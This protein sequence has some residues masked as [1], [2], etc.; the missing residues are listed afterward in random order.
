MNHTRRP[1]LAEANR[2]LTE[3]QNVPLPWPYFIVFFLCL[4]AMVL[5]PF[6]VHAKRIYARLLW[7]FIGLLALCTMALVIWGPP[8]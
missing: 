4:G 5:A 7:T 2:G 1:G 6:T 8:I 3:V